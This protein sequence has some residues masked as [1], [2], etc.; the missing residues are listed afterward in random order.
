[1]RR[2]VARHVSSVLI[3]AVSRSP[4]VYRWKPARRRQAASAAGRSTRDVKVS[5]RTRYAIISLT[6]DSGR[7]V[8][9]NLII[10][11]QLSPTVLRY[12]PFH[13]RGRAHAHTEE[14]GRPRVS[15]SII[16]STY[17][18]LRFGGPPRLDLR[19]FNSSACQ[20]HQC[21]LCSPIVPFLCPALPFATTFR[22][23]RSEPLLASC[24]PSRSFALSSAHARTH[25]RTR[26]LFLSLSRVSPPLPADA[27]FPFSFFPSHPPLALCF[28]L[29]SLSPSIRAPSSSSTPRWND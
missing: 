8:S 2:I 12:I 9:T 23:L 7:L 19:L 4:Q 26:S 17:W 5:I 13:P 28:T 18:G 6:L 16:P 3:I 10:R 14:R 25:R 20:K 15:I 1:M 22:P 24:R 27:P 21:T 29:A 11:D